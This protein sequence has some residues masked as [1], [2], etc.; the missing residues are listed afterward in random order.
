[1]VSLATRL[2]LNKTIYFFN[3]RTRDCNQK[4]SHLVTSTIVHYTRT[5]HTSSHTQKEK[6]IKVLST[7]SSMG[8]SSVNGIDACET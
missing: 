5:T 2:F 7:D 1:M 4:H 6:K 8:L 3:I